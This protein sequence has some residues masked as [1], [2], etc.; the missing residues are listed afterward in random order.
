MTDNASSAVAD[1]YILL[2]C[3]SQ[4]ANRP[5]VDVNE[6]VITSDVYYPNEYLS[7][8]WLI[9]NYFTYFGEADDA[10][11]HETVNLNLDSVKRFKKQTGVKFYY[12]GILDWIRPVTLAAGTGWLDKLELDL[13]TGWYNINVGFDPY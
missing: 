10:I 5:V 8:A 9:Q 12:D 1:G 11:I 6:S 3:V 7:W 4:G 2:Q 13:S